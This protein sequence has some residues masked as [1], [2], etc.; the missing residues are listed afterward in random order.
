M[1]RSHR[2]RPLHFNRS[3]M[4][5]LHRNKLYRGDGFFDDVWD[6]FKGG[7]RGVSH[8]VGALGSVAAPFVSAIHPVAGQYVNIGGHLL[9]GLGVRRLRK[10]RGGRLAT[11]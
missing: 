6:G 7:L 1:R 9:S 3:N 10:R 2:S 11:R 8:V 5:H 4:H